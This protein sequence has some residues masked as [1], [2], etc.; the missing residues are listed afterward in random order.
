MFRLNDALNLYGTISKGRRSPVVQ[1]DA[2]NSVGGVIPRLQLVPE[3][4][5]WNF[6]A[7]LKV[8]SSTLTGTLSAFYQS[9]RGFPVSVVDSSGVSRT[10]SAGSAKNPGVEVEAQW[11]PV[12]PLALFGAAAGSRHGYAHPPP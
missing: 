1:L 5:V 9:Y 3:E 2:Q 11:R 8:A 6:E 7:G 12:R 10:Q 4:N